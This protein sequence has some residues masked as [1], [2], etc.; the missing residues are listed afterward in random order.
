VIATLER[1]MADDRGATMAEYGIIAAGLAV[2]FIAA[3]LAIVT[4]AGTTLQ[5]ATSGMQSI[6]VNP[7]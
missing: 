6:G 4:T 7:P 3:A 5:S 1:M 2:P